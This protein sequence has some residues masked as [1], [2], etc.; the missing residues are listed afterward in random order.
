MVAVEVAGW[1]PAA[2]FLVEQTEQT[3]QTKGGGGTVAS[4]S[5]PAFCLVGM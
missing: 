4:G 3:K 2:L 5:T 1:M